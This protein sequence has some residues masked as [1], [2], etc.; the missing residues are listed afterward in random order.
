M[1]HRVLRGDHQERRIELVGVSIDGHAPLGHGFQQGGLRPWRGPVDL[2]GQQD[3][4]KHRTRPELELGRLRIEDRGS[5][6]V[7]RQQVRRTLSPLET[8]TDT[9][10]KRPG[11]YRLGHTRHVLQQD[12]PLA[13][14]RYQRQD[15]L[16]SLAD[17]DLLDIAR[18]LLG[19][20]GDRRHGGLLS[21]T[22]D[23]MGNHVG[24]RLPNWKICERR[25]SEMTTARS[26]NSTSAAPGS[27]P[28]TWCTSRS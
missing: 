21:K 16:L 4:R 24:N 20:W 27:P 17:D 10:R 26:W 13:E 8:A 6:D 14:K 25:S 3:I 28:Q 2:V 19:D 1:V 15:D 23:T 18:Q 12:V 5:G 22:L 7:G 9:L 11:Q